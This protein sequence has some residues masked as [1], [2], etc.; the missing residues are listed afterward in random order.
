MHSTR[1]SIPLPR[2]THR[3]LKKLAAELD[4][5]MSDLLLEGLEIRL[6]MKPNK[7]TKKTIKNSIAG[8]GVK[9]FDTINEPFEDLGI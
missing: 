9:R 6:K 1:V 4:T 8:K 2:K 5:T 7:L 3:K